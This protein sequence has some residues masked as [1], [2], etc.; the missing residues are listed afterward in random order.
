MDLIER[1]YWFLGELGSEYRAWNTV[2]ITPWGWQVE[3]GRRVR[4]GSFVGFLN[5][6]VPN[7]IDN[8]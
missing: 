3:E 6:R 2:G 8:I 7:M 4:V 5:L 1:T